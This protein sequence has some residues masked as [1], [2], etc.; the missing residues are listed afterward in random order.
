MD[1]Y[2]ERLSETASGPAGHSPEPRNADRP[3][4]A[5][6]SMSVPVPCPCHPRGARQRDL[7]FLSLKTCH[8]DACPRHTLHSAASRGEPLGLGGPARPSE[9]PRW[10]VGAPLSTGALKALQAA[11]EQLRRR[12]F[13]P[14]CCP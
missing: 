2:A 13:G 6:M 7:V 14:G 4:P 9:R 12:T 10:S 5:K 11:Y 1:G 8:V 3:V